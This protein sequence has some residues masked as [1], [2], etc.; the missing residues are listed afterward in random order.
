MSWPTPQDY[1]EAV[2][3]PRIAFTD[4]DLRNGQPELTP[5]GLP[6][7]ISGNFACVYKIQTK[8]ANWAARCFVSEVS[9]LRQRYEA[10]SEHLARTQ[11][12]YTVPFSY[13]PSGIK[14]GNREFPLVKMQ[15]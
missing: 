2:Q 8:Q 4:S 13:L 10:I 12:P 1:N 5:L 11:L 9:D 14:L 15:W 3:N 6:R 7:P